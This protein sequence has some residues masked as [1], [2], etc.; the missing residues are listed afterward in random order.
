MK[1]SLNILVV[2]ILVFSS[3]CTKII[4]ELENGH[5]CREDGTCKY[6]PDMHF[7]IQ[8][9]MCVD[10]GVETRCTSYYQKT[11]PY[12]ATADKG[13]GYTSYGFNTNGYNEAGE[14][15]TE[16]HAVCMQIIVSGNSATYLNIP[17][18]HLEHGKSTQI[19]LKIGSYGQIQEATVQETF[20][21]YNN[22]NEP[23]DS[24]SDVVPIAKFLVGLDNSTFDQN[25]YG[26]SRQYLEKDRNLILN[27][28][29]ECKSTLLNP[30]VMP[31]N[32]CSFVY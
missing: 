11:F 4:D 3:S 28:H 24:I 16:Y 20:I 19:P 14:S 32:E 13:K 5:P 7:L 9:S 8:E 1:M 31:V 25:V 29:A 15:I 21:H 12:T 27:G 10:N 22:Y 18:C 17:T 30:P 2:C 6:N 26:I 23:D